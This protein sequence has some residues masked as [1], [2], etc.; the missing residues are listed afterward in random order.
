M[1]ETFT[2]DGNLIRVSGPFDGIRARRVE[3]VLARAAP[4][5]LLSVDVTQVSEFHEFGLA[6][7]AQALTRTNAVVTL[8]GLGRREALVLRSLGAET[9]RLER[10]AASGGA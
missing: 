6:V 10:A 9:A 1:D 7:L 2:V 5:A 8:V 3:A 4:G